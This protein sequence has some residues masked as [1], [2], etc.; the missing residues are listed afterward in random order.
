[1]SFDHADFSRQRFK[2]PDKVSHEW[3]SWFRDE[4]APTMTKI[5]VTPEA[6]VPFA[7]DGVNRVL[8]DVAVYRG[9]ITPARSRNEVHL[10]TDDDPAILVS[11]AGK[12][13][14]HNKDKEVDLT[15]PGSA[16][17]IQADMANVF[18]QHTTSRILS[19]RLRRRLLEPL[20]PDH[21]PL[22]NLLTIRDPQALRLLTNYLQVLD[23][24][25]TITSPEAKH[26]V[27]THIHDL[28]ALA[29]G[30]SRDAAHAI[31][32][33]GKRAARLAAVKTDVLNNLGNARLSVNAVAARQGVSPRYVQMLFEVEGL[34]FSEFVLEQ[35]LANAYRLLI[36]P[37]CAGQTIQAVALQA[38]FG[39]LSYFNRTFRRRF[40]MTPRDV[41]ACAD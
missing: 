4:I 33:R 20:L 30:A 37:L 13:S 40:G 32:G 41:R 19:V 34:S 1:M 8:P 7:L 11:L 10:A 5:E 31:A 3:L 18:A 14:M 16:V 38:G 2:S 27:T 28:A 29:I 23:T 39:D 26:L 6:D 24:E 12:A 21:S 17:V 15:M 9:S 36:N 35:R 25:E 22:G